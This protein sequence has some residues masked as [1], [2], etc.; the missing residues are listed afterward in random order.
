MNSLVKQIVVISGKGG[1]G[2]TS[3]TAALS[4]CL[5]PL[6]LADCD[7]DATDLHMI[8]SSENDSVESELFESGSMAVIDDELCNSCSTCLKLCRFDS[9]FT[10]RNASGGIQYCVDSLSCEGCGVCVDNCPEGA[11]NEVVRE[12]GRI[13]TSE[14]RFG[15]MIRGALYPGQGNSGK[16]VTIVRNR[17]LATARQ[18]G[19]SYVL[20]DGPPG[21]GCPVIASL[22]GIDIALIVTEPTVAAIHDMERVL[23][24]SSHFKITPL[25]LINKCD[26]N[27]EKTAEIEMRCLQLNVEV[28]GKLPYDEVFTAAMV[29]GKTITEYA[30]GSETAMEI[31]RIA[32]HFITTDFPV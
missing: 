15:K 9:I 25:V 3:V 18:K 14:T 29:E 13:E 5:K 1:T 7:V 26:L 17:A 10:K 22:T 11:I 32:A 21:I 28:A 31:R 2:K 20:A 19:Y 8:A 16:L 6:A 30:P 4:D 27:N 12:A 24:L 23:E